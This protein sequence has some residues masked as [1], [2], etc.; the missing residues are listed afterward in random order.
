MNIQHHIRPCSY[1]ILVATLERRPSKILR[2]QAP[3]LQHRPHSSIEHKYPLREQ[4]SESLSRFVQITH[5][6]NTTTPYRTSCCTG[7]T[8]REGRVSGTSLFYAGS[9]EESNA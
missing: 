5:Q 2:S 7:D 4:L 1:Q 6:G 9:T 8:S 3:L